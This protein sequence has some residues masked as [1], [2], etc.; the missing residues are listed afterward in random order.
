MIYLVHGDDIAKSRAL[1]ANQQKKL[2]VEKR[3]EVVLGET[4]TISI[5]EASKSGDLFG[6]SP[7][8]VVDASKASKTVLDEFANNIEN[9][10]KNAVLIIF[11]NKE[12]TKTNPVLQKVIPLDIR[13]SLSIKTAEGNV[14]KFVDALFSKNRKATYTQLQNLYKEDADTFYIFSMVV[15]GIRNLANVAF[16]SAAVFKM[17]PYVKTKAEAQLKNF[18]ETTIKEIYSKLYELDKKTKTGALEPDLALTLAIEK[19]LNS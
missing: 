15:Y 10:G 12:L 11:F 16:K 6:N 8:L 4:D 19:V 7:F 14:F 9:I 17:N 13:T 3:T 5:I 1:I 2:N 18:D